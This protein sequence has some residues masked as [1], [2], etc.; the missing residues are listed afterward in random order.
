MA[1]ILD[2]TIGGAGSNT[3]T[4]LVE[5]NDYHDAH[6]DGAVWNAV[7]DAQKD[8]ALAM[9][10][11]MFDSDIRWKGYAH[12]L[13]Q[14]LRWPRDGMFDK[15]G[16]YIENDELPRD[17]KN[18][19]AEQARLLLAGD[20]A[21]DRE[22]TGISDLSVGS[23]SLTFDK[24]DEVD[25]IADAAYSMISH[26]GERVSPGSSFKEVTLVRT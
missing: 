22:T 8:V 18:A 19:V 25:V 21:A 3:Y 24:M 1:L 17:L 5:A 23:I 20:R 13:E 12:T 11:R 7:T 14:S 26:L 4:T 15:D 10:T 2:A 6:V 9:A 16:N